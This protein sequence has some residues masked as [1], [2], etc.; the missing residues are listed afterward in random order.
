MTRNVRPRILETAQFVFDVCAEGSLRSEGT[1]IRS[2]QRVRLI[3]AVTR[4]LILAKGEWDDRR[5]GI[6]INQ[7]DLAGTLMTFSVVLLDAL[8]TA[9]I[10]V[11]D[12]EEEAFLHLWKVV[13]H[14]L[15]ITP[16]LL[17]VDVGDARAMMQVIRDDQWASSVQG[18]LLARQLLAS[19]REYLPT[20]LLDDV[21]A[22]L[23]RFFAPAPV[24]ELLGIGD[25]SSLDVVLDAGLRLSSVLGRAARE[26]GRRAL[27]RRMSR[28][29][30][31]GLVKAQRIAQKSA[32]SIP[33][34][35]VRGWKIG[36]TAGS[37]VS[38]LR[39]RRITE[40]A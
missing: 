4:H 37:A 25:T 8:K 12:D 35:L 10:E 14:F 21:P 9:G 5:L 27:V 15:G 18:K 16:A 30:M 29:L 13:G 22:V 31:V 39:S 28:D 26:E 11:A 7:E 20:A 33:S 32:F 3:H 19:M 38:D 1:G 24:P 34:A 2:A 17:P 23:I 6:P 40:D 36:P